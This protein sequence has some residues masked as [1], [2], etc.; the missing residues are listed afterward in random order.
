MHYP[1]LYLL[2][3]IN[4]TNT[5]TIAEIVECVQSNETLYKNIQYVFIET[6]KISPESPWRILENNIDTAVHEI[7]YFQ[8]GSLV[9]FH[10]DYQSTTSKGVPFNHRIDETYDGKTIFKLINRSVVNDDADPPTPRD[11]LYPHSLLGKNLLIMNF[12]LS[13]FIAGGEAM[14]KYK[15]LKRFDFS[16]QV[17]GLERVRGE[18]CVKI[19]VEAKSKNGDGSEPWERTTLW[20]AV[21]KNHLPLQFE[22]RKS[23]LDGEIACVGRVDRFI[24]L[25][26]GV[27][28]PVEMTS[29]G[30]DEFAYI[31]NKKHQ[32]A[33]DIHLEIRDVVFNPKFPEGF[34]RRESIPSGAVVHKIRE[35]K[36][37]ETHR[38]DL[39]KPK[40]ITAHPFDWKWIFY[41][42][43]GLIVGLIV[44][45][46]FLRYRRAARLTS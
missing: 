27:W 41:I 8:H 6:Y 29:H 9:R 42:V 39:A 15:R 13:D 1:F 2:I 4:A 44:V 38:H 7:R 22:S 45:V 16:T 5:P 34:F 25:E 37:I 32:I 43:F 14:K 19:Q 20:L 36:I 18:E 12:P 23:K 11:Y 3:G 46:S 28:F 30:Y 26:E 35:G 21:D 33:N 17:L 31:K 10:D 40:A 24:E